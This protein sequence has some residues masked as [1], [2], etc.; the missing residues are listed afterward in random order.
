MGNRLSKIVTRTGDDGTTGLG[1]GQR[2][3]KDHARI[4]AIGDIDELNSYIGL[5]LCE[6]LPDALDLVFIQFQQ[7]LFN[8]GATLCLPD[9]ASKILDNDIERLDALITRYNAQLP[10]LTE[11]ILPGGTRA[12]ALIQLCR[13]VCR[14][15]ERTLI[16][17]MTQEKT[18][19]TLQLYLNRL[20]DLLFVLARFVNQQAGQLETT[21]NNPARPITGTE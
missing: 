15:A 7:D 17:L 1:D 13:A 9:Y 14:R 11:F 3:N 18:E 4:H 20:S 5:V 12:A 16:T 8:F 10:Y 6:K 2:I 19:P 21:W